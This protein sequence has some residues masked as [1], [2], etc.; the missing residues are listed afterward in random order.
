MASGNTN[1]TVSSQLAAD[2]AWIGHK[3]KGKMKGKNRERKKDTYHAER[4]GNAV[5]GQHPALLRETSEVF[6]LGDAESSTERYE[7]LSHQGGPD[8]DTDDNAKNDKAQVV[9]AGAIFAGSGVVVGQLEEP[10]RVGPDRG[11]EDMG[12]E[13]GDDGVERET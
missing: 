5:V 2:I 4:P 13:K 7:S 1:T 6:L 10:G 3:G 8:A 12:A 11:E 9:G